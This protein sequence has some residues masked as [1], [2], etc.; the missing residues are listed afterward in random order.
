MCYIRRTDYMKIAVVHDWLNGMRGGEKVLEAIL[1]VCPTAT[2][3]TL[4]HEPGRVSRFIESHRIV[5]SWLNRIPGVYRYYRN[6]LPFFPAA[7]ESLDLSGFDLVI[8][9]SHAAAKG[10]RAGSATHICYCHTPMRYIWDGESDYRFDPL[11]HLAISA[12]RKRLQH[13]D[14]ETANNV[15]HFIANSWFVQHRIGKYYGR[16]SEV[17]YPPV[18]TQFFSPSPL[19]RREDFY[20][21][22][23]A[24]VPYKRLDL[25]VQAF[26]KLKHRLVVAGS[27]PQLKALRKM[28]GT[29]VEFRGWVTDEELRRLYRSAKALVMAAREDFGIAAVEAR[30]CGCP[31][32]AFGEGGAAETVQDRINGILF[33]EQRVDEVL[34]AVRRFEAM[35]WPVERVQRRVEIFSRESFQHRIR[36]FIAERIQSNSSAALRRVQSA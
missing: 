28:A 31:V 25:V 24:L 29:N 12:I 1:Q 23:G 17:I 16:S 18:D 21:A 36:K 13:W 33:A 9:S 32:I 8:S 19:T 35:T 15:D 10:I 7:I 26:N 6:F 27:G 4:F 14:R 5:T 2:I 20:L 22:A 3:Y 30:A 11:R 34:H